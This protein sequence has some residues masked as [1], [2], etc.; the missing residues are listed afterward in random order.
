MKA[1]IFMC[2]YFL[3]CPDKNMHNIRFKISVVGSTRVILVFSVGLQSFQGGKFFIAVAGTFDI[4]F[5]LF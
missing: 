2:W 5:S 3:F 4:F 1:G